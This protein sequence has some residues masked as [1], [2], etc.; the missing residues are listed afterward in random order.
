MGVFGQIDGRSGAEL[1]QPVQKPQ[2]E[3]DQPFL[4]LAELDG[5]AT[6]PSRGLKRPLAKRAPQVQ[7]LFRRQSAEDR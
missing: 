3:I 5:E 1:L 6:L 7:V 4:R 2:D